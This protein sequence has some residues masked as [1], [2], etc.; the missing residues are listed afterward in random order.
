MDSTT[1]GVLGIFGILASGAGLLY[2]AINHKKF[3]CVCCGRNMDVSIDID[4]TQPVVV[5]KKKSSEKL[6]EVA[7][8]EK[9]EEDEEAMTPPPIPPVRVPR[10]GRRSSIPLPPM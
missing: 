10:R 3:K 5:V 6:K 2:T 9:K 7:P 4:P 1:S 8:E